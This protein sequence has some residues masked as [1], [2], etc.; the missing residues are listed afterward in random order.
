MDWMKIKYILKH[1]KYHDLILDIFVIG[2]YTII[3][4]SII[5]LT[6]LG[7]FVW[8]SGALGLFFLFLQLIM[9][10]IFSKEMTISP[11]EELQ[12]NAI[13]LL[14]LYLLS[15]VLFIVAIGLYGIFIKKGEEG[16]KL[17]VKITKISELERYL[18]GTIVSILLV[19]ALNKI[20]HPGKTP[21]K[22]NAITIGM[23]CII[24]LVISIY[25]AVQDSKKIED[26]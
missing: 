9:N 1:K 20:L 18:F 25:L 11:L 24:I 7:I 10:L 2:K 21:L 4:G 17:P 16:I 8:I 19:S 22:E 3:C 5:L 13:V 14:D 12:T 26:G 23:I 6:V 15:V